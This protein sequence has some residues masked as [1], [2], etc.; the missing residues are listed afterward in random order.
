[1]N[2]TR[3]ESI[4]VFY[5]PDKCT[6][7]FLNS[8]YYRGTQLWSLLSENVQRSVNIEV[9]TRHIKPQYS[10]YVNLLEN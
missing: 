7:M 8:A 6:T 2:H 4:I 5:I 1:M 3:A 10:K 9:F